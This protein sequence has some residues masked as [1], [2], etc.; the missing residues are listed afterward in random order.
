MTDGPSGPALPRSAVCYTSAPV[1]A[2]GSVAGNSPAVNLVWA[3]NARCNSSFL[4]SC[5]LSDVVSDVRLW[6]ISSIRRLFLLIALLLWAAEC[7]AQERY[8]DVNPLRSPP[9]MALTRLVARSNATAVQTDVA[10]ANDSSW[11]VSVMAVPPRP[12]ELR[13]CHYGK[14]AHIARAR[15]VVCLR[16]NVMATARSVGDAPRSMSSASMMVERHRDGLATLARLQ[17]LRR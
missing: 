3:A 14:Y 6:F 11:T 16:R 17:L 5:N 9:D 12:N 7:V 10:T 15:L 8:V 4:L 2:F 1:G 13:L